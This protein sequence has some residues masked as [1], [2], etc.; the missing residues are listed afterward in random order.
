LGFFFIEWIFVFKFFKPNFGRDGRAYRAAIEDGEMPDGLGSAYYSC[1]S[2]AE[3]VG[4][5]H[6]TPALAVAV[7]ALLVRSSQKP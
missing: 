5:R 4:R 3:S 7:A 6:H 2:S 1:L